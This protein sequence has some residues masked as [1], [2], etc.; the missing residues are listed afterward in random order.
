MY[1]E[2]QLLPILDDH[3]KKVG[4]ANFSPLLVTLRR[5]LTV[6]KE[7]RLHSIGVFNPHAEAKSLQEKGRCLTNKE[8][9]DL[10]NHNKFGVTGF[11]LLDRFLK[12]CATLNLFLTTIYLPV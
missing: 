9:M 10:D 11:H 2:A 4:S 12:V 7:Q 6:R 8:R 1:E 3:Y 5:K